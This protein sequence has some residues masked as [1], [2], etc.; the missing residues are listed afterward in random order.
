MCMVADFVIHAAPTGKARP[1]VTRFGTYTPKKTK[2]YEDLVKSEFISQ[3]IGVNFGDGPLV[4]Y[5]KAIYPIPK[6]VSKS[7][8]M[9]MIS[10]EIRPKVK[11]DFDNVCKAVCDALNGL[12]YNDDAQIVEAHCFKFYG[13]IPMV[14][15]TIEEV[16][17]V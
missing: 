12:A 9:R 6:S 16:A 11:P 4:I 13:E 10:G 17:N 5:V 8:R 1:R 3:C 15:V 14:F 2:Q 7:K